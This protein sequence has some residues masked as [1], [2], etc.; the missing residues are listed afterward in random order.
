VST[1]QPSV[2]RAPRVPRLALSVQE[3]CEAL[4]CGWDFFAE[5]VAPELRVVRRGRRKMIAV[6]ELERWLEANAERALPDATGI[7]TRTG[8]KSPANRRVRASRAPVR[9]ARMRAA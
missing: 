8:A 6:A 2:S 9:D 5:H 3:A 1:Q 4:G 7:D